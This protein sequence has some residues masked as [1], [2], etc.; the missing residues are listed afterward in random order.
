MFVVLD[1]H[2]RKK[3]KKHRKSKKKGSKVVK[4]EKKAEEKKGEG[5]KEEEK[6]E[7]SKEVKKEDKGQ[8]AAVLPV[9]PSISPV[10]VDMQADALKAW[11]K[12]VCDVFVFLFFGVM[13]FCRVCCY[14]FLR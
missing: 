7:E 11:K 8:G 4:T 6:K 1:G 3:K 12:G 2:S 10:N 5:K 9:A 14:W 13:F